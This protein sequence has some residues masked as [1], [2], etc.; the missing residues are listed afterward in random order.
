MGLNGSV[1]EYLTCILLLSLQVAHSSS[2]VK[3]SVLLQHLQCYLALGL[4]YPCFNENA[5]TVS[6]VHTHVHTVNLIK[7]I[8]VD[9]IHRYCI[10]MFVVV[11]FFVKTC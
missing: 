9:Y 11:R 7:Y 1:V 4:F 3:E 2:L 10:L 5:V 8:F 6:L